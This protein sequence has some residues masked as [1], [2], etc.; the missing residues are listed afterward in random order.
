MDLTWPLWS[1][2]VFIPAAARFSSVPE[3]A[4]YTASLKIHASVSFD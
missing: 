4:L 1:M 2:L 3:A